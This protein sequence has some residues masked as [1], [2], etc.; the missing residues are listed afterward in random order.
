MDVQDGYEEQGTLLIIDDSAD[1]IR[2]LSEMLADV[3]RI[4]FATSGAEGLKLAA[5]RRPHL[6]LLDVDMPRMDGYQVCAQLKAAPETR[7]AS[8]IF[9]TGSSDSDS[10]IKALEMGAVDFITKPL[11]PPV[12]RARVRAHL[13]LQLQANALARL[14][15]RDGLTGLYNRRYFDQMVEKE[16]QRHKRLEQPLA[17]ALIDI[18]HFK[19]YNDNYGHQE[20]DACLRR[21]AQAIGTATRRPAEVVAR[22][23]GEEFVVL[24]PHTAADEAAKYG[25]W[26]CRHIEELGLEHRYSSCG[27]HVTISAG[28]AVGVPA[29]ADTSQQL[30]R[31]AD[32]ALYRAKREGRNRAV[33]VTLAK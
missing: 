30:I 24:L 15:T 31:A 12:V 18:D 32:Q 33:C 22:F 14:A 29:D 23:G 2:L 4:Y 5:E 28:I 16:F 20:G 11:V 3:G 26:L 9:V 10:E 19:P 7:A 1:M 6:I 27:T 21:V 13:K 8:V 25:D 17:L